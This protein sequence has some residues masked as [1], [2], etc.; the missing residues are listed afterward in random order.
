MKKI[1]F[2][3]WKVVKFDHSTTFYVNMAIKPMFALNLQ[4]ISTMEF[5]RLNWR[6]VEYKWISFQFL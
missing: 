3:R 6:P 4:P 2:A 1:V 5:E